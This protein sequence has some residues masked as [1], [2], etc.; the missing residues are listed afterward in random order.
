MDEPFEHI[1]QEHGEP[2][3]RRGLWA[4]RA[5]LS[6]AALLPLAALANVIGQS[7][8]DA[9][10][11]AP[12]ARLSLSAPKVVRGGLLFQSR[13]QVV[14]TRDIDHLRLVLGDGWVQDMQ[15]SSIE[16]DP[17]DESSRNGHVVLS[18]GRLRADDRLVVWV[19]SQ[20]DPTNTGRRDASLELQD[21]TTSL[22][23]ID[24][25]ITVLP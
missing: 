13:V 11:T 7:P 21:A 9:T 12:A 15:I 24:R 3:Q 18:Y 23:R 2:S 22:A 5:M 10:T 14:A 16:P 4:R 17:S 25:T 1:A 19:Q 20:V 6:V 8:S